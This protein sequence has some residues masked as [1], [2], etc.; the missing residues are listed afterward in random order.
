MVRLSLAF[1]FEAAKA[2]LDAIPQPDPPATAL[3]GAAFG[4]PFSFEGNNPTPVVL[5]RLDSRELP[6]NARRF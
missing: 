1:D 5:G 3:D 4:P 2:E 6:R